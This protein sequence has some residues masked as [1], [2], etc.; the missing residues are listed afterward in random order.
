[1]YLYIIQRKILSQKQQRNI[2]FWQ[3]YRTL[4]QQLAFIETSNRYLLITHQHRRKIHIYMCMH[5]LTT[6]SLHWPQRFFAYDFSELELEHLKREQK[7]TI[8]NIYSMEQYE[9]DLQQFMSSILSSQKHITTLINKDILS[10]ARHIDV[11]S[12]KDQQIAWLSFPR[13][14]FEK[15]FLCAIERQAISFREEEPDSILEHHESQIYPRGGYNS[16]QIVVLFTIFC[17]LNSSIQTSI[18]HLL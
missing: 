2:S 9:E 15:R 11:L 12:E 3:D 14:T 4:L 8:P 10:I 18:Y 16:Y 13:H 6:I 5:I 7:D 1:M 17:P